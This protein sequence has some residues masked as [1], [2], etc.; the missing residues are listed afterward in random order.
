MP[1]FSFACVQAR[2]AAT[3]SNIEK[4][5]DKIRDVNNRYKSPYREQPRDLYHGQRPRG[6]SATR[7]RNG[8][9][10]ERTGGTGSGP[11]TPRPGTGQ[12][13]RTSPRGLKNGS[14]TPPRGR[15]S[16]R[17]GGRKLSADGKGGRSG[18]GSRS[19]SRG[20]SR[21]KRGRS[22]SRGGSERSRDDDGGDSG[23]DEVVR[24]GDFLDRELTAVKESVLDTIVR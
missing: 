24:L 10:R 23:D 21:G 18:S 16:D 7:S 19:D 9:E 11:M 20:S 8:A 6:I 17:K 2:E 22:S 13:P 12:R 4:T 1:P 14:R 15:S 3:L 5:F